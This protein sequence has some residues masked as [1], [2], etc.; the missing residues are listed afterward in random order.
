MNHQGQ[1]P[2]K[3]EEIK[4]NLS[5][6]ESLEKLYRE[7]KKA[8]RTAFDEIYPQI[9]NSEGAKFWKARLEYE[10]KPEFLKTFTLT[11]VLTVLTA[12]LI[13]AFLIKIRDLFNTGYPEDV[14]YMKNA[15]IIVFFGLSLYAARTIIIQGNRKFIYFILLFLL[16]ALYINLLPSRPASDSVELVYI[17]LPF[18]MWFMYGIVFTGFD[19]RSPGVRSVYIH[20]SGDLAVVYALIAIA[21][22]IL[23]GISIGLFESIGLSIE[24]FYINNIVLTGAVSA[25][26]VASWFTEKFPALVSKI[27]PLIAGIFSPIVLLTLVIFL[28]AMA[29]KG[30]DLYNDR[31]FLL[32]FNIMLLGVMG[33]IIFSVSETTVIKNQ[34]FNAAILLALSIVTIIVDLVALSAIFYR[35]NEF[36][37]TPNRLAVLVSNLLVLSN[38]ILIMADLFRINFRGQDFDLVRNTVTRYLP[39]YLLWILI[40]VFGF[41]FFFGV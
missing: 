11:E 6:P 13:T 8:F 36:G 31:D 33:L 17:H 39:V 10:N 32:I 25:P 4:L 18:L 30:T 29:V 7:N 24:N 9:I 26:I 37:L 2:I 38:V 19:L 41:P 20:H 3:A 1:K 35:L 40:V 27:T 22:G 23:T 16:P 28:I 15:A 12:C 21:G 34:K 5:R 14:F